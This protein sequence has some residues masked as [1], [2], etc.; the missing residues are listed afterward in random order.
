MGSQ[1]DELAFDQPP[2]TADAGGVPQ[3]S[4]EEAEDRLSLWA[5]NQTELAQHL[6]CERKSI[7]R[8]LKSGDPECPGRT[9][10]GRYNITLWKLWIS[11]AGKQVRSTTRGKD[12]GDL[13]IE[14]MGLRNEKLKIENMLRQGELMHVD[15]V[16]KVLTDMLGAAVLRAKQVKHTLAGA[17]IGVSLP[18]ATKRIDREVHEVLSE[19]S[20]GDWAKKKAFWSS[21]YAHLQDL[22]AKISLGDGLSDTSS[23]R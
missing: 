4:A 5:K 20:L 3:G 13:E 11:K 14:N 16:C 8:W 23:T 21:V 7:Q 15:E 12:K 2:E 22:Q 1:D 19:L 9:P 6:E 17:V 18:E 10:D